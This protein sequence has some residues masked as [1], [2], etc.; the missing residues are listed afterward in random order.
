MFWR[1]ND[2]CLKTVRGILHGPNQLRFPS[3]VSPQVSPSSP[4]T[5]ASRRVHFLL[6][7]DPETRPQPHHHGR[8]HL[9]QLTANVCRADVLASMFP[10]SPLRK[11]LLAQVFQPFNNKYVKN[12]QLDL[13]F[14]ANFLESAEISKNSFSVCLLPGCCKKPAPIVNVS[15]IS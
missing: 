4:V 2:C 3:T 10:W 8:C 5:S 1:S 7:S 15:N 14:Q 9:R 13:F 12:S 6:A 11:P